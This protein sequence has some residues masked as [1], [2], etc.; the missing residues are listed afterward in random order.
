MEGF[1]LPCEGCG[2]PITHDVNDEGAK[3]DAVMHWLYS[4]ETELCAACRALPDS[5]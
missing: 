1:A 4:E 5:A 2:A 3:H